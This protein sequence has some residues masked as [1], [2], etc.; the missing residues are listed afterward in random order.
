MWQDYALG[1]VQAMFA[2]A[3]MPTLLDRQKPALSTSAMN[4]AGMTIITV[5][6]VS[7]LLWLSAAVAAIVGFQWV[8]LWIQRYNQP[9][10]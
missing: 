4:A 3:L 7:L 8:I 10:V 2:V 6:Y 5:V 1:V 9:K